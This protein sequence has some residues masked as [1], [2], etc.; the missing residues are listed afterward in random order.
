MDPGLIRREFSALRTAVNKARAH[1]TDRLA[2]RHH[3]R[4]PIDPVQPFAPFLKPW[5]KGVPASGSAAKVY[6]TLCRL[7][8]LP[9]VGHIVLTD[10]GDYLYPTAALPW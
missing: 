6:G 5:P 1:R 7:W 2:P 8:V 4:S 3:G 10:R 9:G